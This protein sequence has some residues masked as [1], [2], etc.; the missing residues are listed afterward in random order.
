L[1]LGRGIY[2][3]SL[4]TLF[5]ATVMLFGCSTGQK[6][7]AEHL[8]YSAVFTLDDST[9]VTVLTEK[10]DGGLVVK[11]GEEDVFVK[12]Q[13]EGCY[14]VPVFGGSWTGEWGGG[15]WTGDWI[16][17]LRTEDYRVRL[18]VSPLENPVPVRGELIN[19]VW[20]TS[21]GK[22]KFTQKGD[23]AW[24]TFLTSTGDYR[25]QAGKIDTITHEF[26]IQNF[27]GVHLFYFEGVIKGDSITDGVFKSGV[28]YSTSW[29]GV[30]AENEKV[31]WSSKQ[32][33][34]RGE[35]VVFEG[36]NSGGDVE[37]WSR[38]RFK[39]SGYKLLVVDVM[40]TWCPNCMDEVRLLTELSLDYPEMLVVSVSFERFKGDEALR[41]IAE[42]KESLGISWEILHGGTAS[43]S[44]ADSCLAFFG[45]IK[46]FPTTAFIPIE[47]DP[48]VH[49]GFSG[50][51]TGGA[52]EEE[53]AFF[54]ETIEA[55]LND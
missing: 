8:F 10:I 38:E 24:A 15:V 37:V 11:N 21:I 41:R 13:G 5:V 50:P 26:K 33:W 18:E 39:K 20:D 31:R 42:F 22:F 14:S 25:Y 9:R 1:I 17:S 29:S 2:L 16:D 51:A 7:S 3:S 4:A 47:G 49:S 36:V 35:R 32:E 28:H 43:K 40:G 46:S 34:G 6:K 54:R 12:S 44:E 23:S 27:D 52:Y 45:G 53:V 19:S 48:I 30:R 55:F